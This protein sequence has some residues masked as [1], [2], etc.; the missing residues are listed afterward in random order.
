MTLALRKI[1]DGDFELAEFVSFAPPKGIG[2]VVGSSVVKGG[3]Y[4]FIDNERGEYAGALELKFANWSLKAIGVVSTKRPD[5]SDGWSFLLF[6]FGQFKVHIAFG[7][8]WTGV[9]GMIGLHHRSD[10][11]ALGAGMRTGA[12][13]DVLFPRNPVA[14]AP[15]IVNRYRTL[16]PI[17]ERQPRL[18]A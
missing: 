15:R 3:G 10:V 14:D 11:D 1:G 7:I 4:L 13:D 8:F 16:F 18:R 5:G 9:G 6:V 12:L 17:A 2:L